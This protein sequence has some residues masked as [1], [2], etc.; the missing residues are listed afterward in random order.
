MSNVFTAPMLPAYDQTHQYF[1]GLDFGQSNDYTVLS[2]FDKTD[3]CQVSMLRIN[4]MEW[5]ELRRRV[6]E[7][8]KRW[9][10]KKMIAESNSIGGPNID[11]IRA[12]GVTVEAFETTNAS[13]A[14]I[15]SDANENIHAGG[16]KLQDHPA[17][18]HEYNTF[19]SEQ[20]STGVWRLASSGNGHDDTVIAS[21]LGM[22]A[23]TRPSG[24]ALLGF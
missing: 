8:H 14:D 11:A 3:K 24:L 4:K 10:C 15:M 13:K 21:A 1:C 18:R 5:A 22:L 16:W 7:E 12:A 23:C 17:Q 19:V 20:T 6:V 9:H 2:V